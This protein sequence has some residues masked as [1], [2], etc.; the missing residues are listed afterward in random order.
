MKKLSVLLVIGLFCIPMLVYGF[1]KTS[2]PSVI[3][4]SISKSVQS[5]VKLTS[6]SIDTAASLVDPEADPALPPAKNPF[7]TEP[8]G[9]KGVVETINT[10]TRSITLK[11][12]VYFDQAVNQYITTDLTVYMD[13]MTTYYQDLDEN[14]VFESLSVGSTVICNGPVNFGSKEIKYAYDVYMGKFIPD[15]A[16]AAIQFSANIKNFDAGNRSFDFDFPGQ[17]GRIYTVHAVI[18]DSTPVF[19]VK[20]T[21]P[22]APN[23]PEMGVIPAF[24]KNETFMHGSFIINQDLTAVANL[25]Y[26]YEY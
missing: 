10:E 9:A 21:A 12:A 4:N 15:D 23:G 8:S 13:D 5:V 19:S 17:D 18:Q 22:E 16:K 25:V 14:S 7:F 3:S 20:Q 2:L 11:N 1:T 6:R 24:V 26:F